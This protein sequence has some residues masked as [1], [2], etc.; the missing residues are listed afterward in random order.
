[1]TDP[2]NPSSDALFP[3]VQWK[4]EVLGD[5]C[6][7]IAATHPD[8]AALRERFLAYRAASMRDEI[9]D[10]TPPVQEAQEAARIYEQMLLRL[11]QRP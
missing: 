7:A 10:P 5:F 9:T 2:L 11:L 6:S 3:I 8:A 1:M 4:L